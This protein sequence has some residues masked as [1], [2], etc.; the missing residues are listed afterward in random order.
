[1]T[2]QN[3]LNTFCLS[4]IKENECNKVESF[5]PKPSME[6]I[7]H[8]CRNV[9]TIIICNN[10][11]PSSGNCMRHYPKKHFHPF[12]KKIHFIPTKVNQ[13]YLG[14]FFSRVQ[15][16]NQKRRYLPK[17]YHITK[18]FL[19]SFILSIKLCNITI[20]KQGNL[21]LVRKQF[22]T[23]N[24]KSQKHTNNC[25]LLFWLHLLA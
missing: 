24:S 14:P 22:A 12:G 20:T 9:Y 3:Q 6:C 10:N 8:S 17:R 16:T 7:K 1:M 5:P 13:G 15:T 18:L 19:P 21:F 11:R 4:H 23:T 2:I 25:S